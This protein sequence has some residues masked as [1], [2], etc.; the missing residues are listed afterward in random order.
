[1]LGSGVGN[2]NLVLTDESGSQDVALPISEH[3]IRYGVHRRTVYRNLERAW[4]RY[5]DGRSSEQPPSPVASGGYGPKRY[6]I[7]EFDSWWRSLPVDGRSK[8]REIR[9]SEHDHEVRERVAA[10][11]RSLLAASGPSA[12]R[13]RSVAVTAGVDPAA[14]RRL[15]PTCAALLDV[16]GYRSSAGRRTPPEERRARTEPATAVRSRGRPASRFTE[17][18]QVSLLTKVGEGATVKQAAAA[19]DITSHLVHA[20]A[21][22]DS[23]FGRRLNEALINGCPAG[24]LCGTYTGYL[25]GGHCPACRKTRPTN[26]RNRKH[27]ETVNPSPGSRKRTA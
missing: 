21:R 26:P 14:V 2:G 9:V 25:T 19:L 5:R 24:D 13:H 8:G 12:V 4:K 22:R 11:A 17:E 3:A 1:M 23:E 7:S 16:A 6:V 15:Y 27:A 18:L 10:A 20:Y